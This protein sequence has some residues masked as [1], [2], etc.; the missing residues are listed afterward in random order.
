MKK[1]FTMEQIIYLRV[2]NFL[3]ALTN[4]SSLLYKTVLSHMRN[5]VVVDSD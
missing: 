3:L 2:N 1:I 5:F 4:E